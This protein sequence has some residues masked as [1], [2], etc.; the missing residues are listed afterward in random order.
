MNIKHVKEKK[1]PGQEMYMKQKLKEI[2]VIRKLLE[3][4]CKK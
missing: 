3:D 1:S 4:Q 2:V